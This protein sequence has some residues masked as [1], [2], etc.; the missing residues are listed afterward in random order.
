VNIDQVL[1]MVDEFALAMRDQAKNIASGNGA[2]AM[3]LNQQRERLHEAIRTLAGVVTPQEMQAEQAAQAAIKS[4]A[5]V[6]APVDGKLTDD[7]NDPR[8]T[9][10]HDDSPAPQ[11]EAYLVLSVEERAKGFVRPYR[12]AYRH[13]TCGSVTTMG[14]ALSETYARDPKFYGGTYCVKCQ[15]HRPVGEFHWYEMDGTIGPVVGA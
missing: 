3:M 9:R 11:A 13:D 12:D 8:L 1:H 2:S 10:G 6:P 7:P 14:R 15:M 4:A 5:R